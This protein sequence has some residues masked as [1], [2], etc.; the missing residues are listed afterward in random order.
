MLC[1]RDGT[2]Y[3]V[4]RV[5]PC[6]LPALTPNSTRSELEL[7]QMHHCLRCSELELRGPRNGLE[8]D[9]RSSRGARP[10]PLF[11]LTPNLTTKG[12]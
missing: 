5:P 4:H 1:A 8:L 9:P 7:P 12:A 10:A 2:C 3:R 6:H 11:A